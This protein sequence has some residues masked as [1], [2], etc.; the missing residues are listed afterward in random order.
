MPSLFGCL[1]AV[2]QG[3]GFQKRIIMGYPLRESQF[4]PTSR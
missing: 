1:Q 3:E 2:C 4:D